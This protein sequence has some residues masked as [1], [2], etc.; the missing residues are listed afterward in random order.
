MTAKRERERERGRNSYPFPLPWIRPC[1]LQGCQQRRPLPGSLQKFES[2]SSVFAF[3]RVI[4]Y[5]MKTPAKETL[6]SCAYCDGMIRIISN[7]RVG[8]QRYYVVSRY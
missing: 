2:Y 4:T 3:V 1:S 5:N 6:H 8:G 7:G